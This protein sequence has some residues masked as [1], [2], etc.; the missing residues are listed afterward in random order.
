MKPKILL[1]CY[2]FPPHPGIGGRRWAKFSKFLVKRGFDLTVI[3]AQNLSGTDSLWTSDIDFN[4]IK[5]LSHQFD[6][7]KVLIYPDSIIERVVRKVL[8]KLLRL[9]NYTPDIITSLPNKKLW[10]QVEELIKANE[11]KNVI[12]TGDPFLFYYASLLKQTLNINLILDYRDLWNDHSFYKSYVTLSKKQQHFFEFAENYALNHCNK[13]ICVDEGVKSTLQKRIKNNTEVLVI[14][15]G[16][17]N[18]EF[19]NITLVQKPTDKI[20]IIFAGGIS[21]DNNQLIE[22]F[23]NEFINFRKK[24]ETLFN[25]ME[26]HILSPCDHSLA[27]KFESITYSNFVFRNNFINK[28][29]YLSFVNQM[30][31]GIIFIS[32]EYTSSFATKFSDYLKLNILTISLGYR[33]FF[34]KF[35]CDHNIGIHFDIEKVNPHFFEDLINLSKKSHLIDKRITEKFDIETLTNDVITI[36]N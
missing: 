22:A 25:S 18:D 20:R 13:V 30:D 9:T 28:E 4:K 27:K 15:N 7:Q 31:F 10:K 32:K 35:I 12:V 26:L 14:N 21:S 24:S 8:I 2:S 34:S 23:V 19:K 16:F 5:L 11:I 36:L 17:D 6:L 1:I 29:D 3:N 33:G